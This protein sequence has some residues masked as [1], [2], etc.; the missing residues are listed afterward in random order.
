MAAP[1]VNAE[2]NE[3]TEGLCQSEWR[4]LFESVEDEHVPS[5]DGN[6]TDLGVEI[7]RIVFN[8]LP[9]PVIGPALDE[10]FRTYW[11]ALVNDRVELERWESERQPR[12][13][14][15]ALLAARRECRRYGD[16]YPDGLLDDIAR[17]TD[18]LHGGAA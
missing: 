8:L 10:L 13:E 17:L 11:A 2:F 7:G 16:P 1:D 12:A 4:A 6:G 14:L 9:E 5:P 15:T 18:E 3:I